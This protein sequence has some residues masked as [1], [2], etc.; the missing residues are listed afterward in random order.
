MCIYTKLGCGLAS[1]AYPK[2]NNLNVTGICA[3][4]LSGPGT[5][6]RM[7]I[8][9]ALSPVSFAT[10]TRLKE[11]F[12]GC[13]QKVGLSYISLAKPMRTG[14]AYREMASYVPPYVLISGG[15]V[16]R[17]RARQAWW[18]RTSGVCKTSG[19]RGEHER[20]NLEILWTATD[21]PQVVWI[22][23]INLCKSTARWA[24]CE[25]KDA[26]VFLNG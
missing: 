4:D 20:G 25:E 26:Q 14:H 11:I 13:E 10:D 6:D 19:L 23:S 16:K 8:T 24:S 18:P 12:F 9:N 17:P 15:V 2:A 5:R 21:K 7:L 3:V 1:V 22:L